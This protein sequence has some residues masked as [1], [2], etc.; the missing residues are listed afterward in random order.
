MPNC[1]EDWSPLGNMAMSGG[2]VPKFG[3]SEAEA[4]GLARLGIGVSPGGRGGRLLWII[5]DWGRCLL[6]FAVTVRGGLEAPMGE[7]VKVIELSAPV[8]VGVPEGGTCSIRFGS[9]I[10]GGDWDGRII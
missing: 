2:G 6:W 7:V 10:G 4:I 9:S 1:I 3:R 8:G 5:M